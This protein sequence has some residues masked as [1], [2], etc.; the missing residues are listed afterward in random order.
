MIKYLRSSSK[1]SYNIKKKVPSELQTIK[2]GGSQFLCGGSTDLC[3]FQTLFVCLSL[4][5]VP[6]SRVTRG[7]GFLGGGQA[8]SGGRCKEGCCKEVCGSQK[9]RAFWS[10]A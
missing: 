7:S 1:C 4:V 6:E 8:Y 3:V 9:P 2:H 10:A 5:R